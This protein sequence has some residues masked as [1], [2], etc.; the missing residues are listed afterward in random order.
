MQKCSALNRMN[1]LIECRILSC[2]ML[3]TGIKYSSISNLRNEV[4]KAYCRSGISILRVNSRNIRGIYC[5]E[6][7]L[8]IIEEIGGIENIII[9]N[10][11]KNE[12]MEIFLESIYEMLISYIE[13][14]SREEE[15]SNNNSNGEDIKKIINNIKMINTIIPYL[16]DK[17]EELFSLMYLLL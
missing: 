2:D 9:K 1:F 13:Y 12:E 17:N 3:Y 8:E 4:I 14:I 5:Y 15:K 16:D 11:K 7:V 6:R 10:E